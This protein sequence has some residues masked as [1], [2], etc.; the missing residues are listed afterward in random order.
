M[1]LAVNPQGYPQFGEN[2]M[3]VVTSLLLTLWITVDSR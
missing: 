3:L 2:Y 1:I